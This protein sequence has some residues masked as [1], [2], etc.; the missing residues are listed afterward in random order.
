MSTEIELTF[1]WEPFF[2]V[3]EPFNYQSESINRLMLEEGKEDLMQ[4]R[5]WMKRRSSKKFI[6]VTGN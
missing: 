6:N 1:S 5:H 2:F 4:M 3:D